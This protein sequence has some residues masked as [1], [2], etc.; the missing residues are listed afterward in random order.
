MQKEK[1]EMEER[2]AIEKE[3]NIISRKKKKKIKTISITRKRK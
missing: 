1:I 3:K 2:I